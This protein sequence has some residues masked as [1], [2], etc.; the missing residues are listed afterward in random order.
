MRKLLSIILLFSLV[1]C[2][3]SAK[4][5]QSWY[6]INEPVAP[7]VGK[8]TLVVAMVKNETSRRII[9]DQLV[10]RFKNEAVAS[11]RMLTPEMIKAAKPE[12][13]EK[14]VVDGGF[15]HVLLMRLTN[16]EEETR[17]VPGTITGYYGGYGMYYGYGA[18][19]YSSPGYYTTDK[20]Y[21]VETAVFTVNPN[22]LIYTCTTSIENPKKVDKATNQIADLVAE[23][24]TKQ[25][26]LAK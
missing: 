13:L 16:A 6:D 11:Y 24:M 1:S 23:R 7:I 15:S 25:G 3:P 12:A 2:G 17:Y 4:V 21:D 22:K 19:F 10:K 8:K 20:K 18:T 26:F 14:F 5:I 9:E